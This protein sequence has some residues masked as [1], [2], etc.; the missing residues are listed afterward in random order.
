MGGKKRKSLTQMEKAQRRLERKKAMRESRMRELQK[1]GSSRIIAP[2]IKSKSVLEEIRKMKVLT[3]YTVASRFNL[4]LSVAKD[5]LEE[6]HRRGVV[7]Y[8]SGS[9]N[10]KIYT[11]AG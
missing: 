7:T 3:P 11:P 8:V 4:R 1:K 9:R 10:L 2:D 6:L 5:M